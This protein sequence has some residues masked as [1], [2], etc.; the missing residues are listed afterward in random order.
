MPDAS[1]PKLNAWIM[2]SIADGDVGPTGRF[3][4]RCSAVFNGT[5][6]DEYKYHA[7]E[8]QADHPDDMVGFRVS[9]GFDEVVLKRQWRHGR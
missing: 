7:C 1:E 8:R 6:Y 9:E 4:T 3:E 5:L 2:F